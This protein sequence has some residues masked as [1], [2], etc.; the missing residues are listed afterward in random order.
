[1]LIH[2]YALLV[3][4]GILG[5]LQQDQCADT[6]TAIVQ[7]WLQEVS[8]T[9]QQQ[10]ELQAQRVQETQAGLQ[11][12]FVAAAAAVQQLGAHVRQAEQHLTAGGAGAQDQQTQQEPQQHPL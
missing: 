12:L 6:A 7:A 2:D 1:M 8:P 5:E 10:A 9:E 3:A 4:A 11:H